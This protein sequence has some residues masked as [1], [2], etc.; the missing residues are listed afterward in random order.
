VYFS[1]EPLMFFALARP[2]RKQ[3]FLDSEQEYSLR[4]LY[5]NLCVS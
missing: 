5:Q 1:W 4:A 3:P 2:R